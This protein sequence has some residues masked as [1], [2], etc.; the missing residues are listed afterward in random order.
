MRRWNGWGDESTYL[1]L[2]DNGQAF[3][4][5]KVGA[6]SPLAN[7]TYEEVEASV[8]ESRLAESELYT[9]A[10]KDRILHARGQSLPDWL[11]MKSGDIGV[12]P[13][14]VSYPESS[15]DVR[16]LLDQAKINN[17]V[18]IPYGGGT[19]VVGHINPLQDERP[20][21]TVDMGR[22]CRLLDLDEQ[23][24]IATFGAGVP[25]PLLESQLQAKG[26]T[27]GHFPQSF[28]LST[29]GG[30]VASRSSG[31]QS[32]KYGRIEQMFAGGKI[33]TLDGT[34]DI[35]TY[36]ASSAG[37]DIREW[38]MGS[39]G[40]FGI[41]TEAKIRVTPIAEQEKFYV[42]FLPSWVSALNCVRSMV[43][44]G[45]PMSMMRLSNAV[46]T[47][48]QLALAGHEGQINL[49]EK[50]L[51]FRGAGEGKC[52]M[53]FGLTHNKAQNNLSLS[54]VK[55]IISRFDGVYTGTMLGKRWKEKRFLFPYLR[56]TLWERGYAVDTLETATDWDN[57]DYLLNE[58][59]NNLR[60]ALN[61][62]GEKVHV[63]T[64]LSHFY[65][66]GCSIYTTYVYRTGDSYEET[67]ERW[68]KLK[69]STSELIVN[70]RGT[71]SHQHGV[72]L[73]HA[74]YMAVEKGEV[75]TGLIRHAA[76]YFDQKGQLNPGKLLVDPP[77]SGQASVI[78][79]NNEASSE[80]A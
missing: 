7:A 43:Q 66:Q 17:W 32:L 77:E 76:Q 3:L 1:E 9:T 63:F 12:F 71:I 30:W 14:A 47:E 2:P 78:E 19:S 59:E 8:P 79:S 60:T 62:E 41:I 29:L 58:I 54:Q 55:K 74:P 11:A 33:E 31:Q 21:I 67:L 23:S 45:I 53:T 6:A 27:L 61:V 42:A 65:N 49:L 39:E 37:P 73:D 70:N 68:K 40:R 72:G 51:K 22:M 38:F 4:E 69:H 48:T 36:P 10:K 24:R 35:P 80:S 18:V 56:E 46:E 25:G 5:D 16:A 15:D 52:M 13:D 75:S 28:E 34:F 50:F 20:I 57:V 64:H 44:A 26:Y